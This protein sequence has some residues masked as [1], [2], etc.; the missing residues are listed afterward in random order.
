MYTPSSR[1]G[2]TSWATARSAG[3]YRSVR[4]TKSAPRSGVAP[5]TMIWSRI[6][7]GGPG[8]VDPAAAVG[9]HHGAGTGRGGRAHAVDRRVHTGALVV[10]GAGAEH[11]GACPGA[12]HPDRAQR[13]DVARDGRRSEPGDRARVGLP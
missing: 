1:L 11:Q 12:L 13:A 7:T 10:V 9:Q 2:S 4:S 3:V 5:V 6:S 8:G